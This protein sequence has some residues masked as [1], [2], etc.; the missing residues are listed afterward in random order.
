M[1]FK[2]DITPNVTVADQPT[3]EDLE[4]CRS[5]GYAGVVNLRQENEPEQPLSPAEEGQ[6]VHELGMEYLHVPVGG[7]PLSEA[8]VASVCEFIDRLAGAGA[9]VLVHCRKGGR[10]MALVLIQQA[11]AHGWT[12]EEAIEKGRQM[13]LEVDGPL[14]TLVEAYLAQSS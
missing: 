2:R 1:N 5:E 6:R 3:V 8:G 10:A 14:R 11:R 13:G 4:A 12:V 7:A 9:K